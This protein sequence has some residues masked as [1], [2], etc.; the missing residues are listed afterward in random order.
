MSQLRCQLD[1]RIYHVKRRG[2]QMQQIADN[3]DDSLKENADEKGNFSRS[4][5]WGRVIG[6]VWSATCLE[7]SSTLHMPSQA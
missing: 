3:N 6:G 1:T 4:S 5:H 2:E 7:Y